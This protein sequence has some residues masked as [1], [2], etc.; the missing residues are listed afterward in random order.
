M[1]I[2]LKCQNF[3]LFNGVHVIWFQWSQGK[4]EKKWFRVINRENPSTLF[5]FTL[6]A[7]E[8]NLFLPPFLPIHYF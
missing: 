6:T 8:L 7:F 5:T 4:K 2:F 1:G 3:L